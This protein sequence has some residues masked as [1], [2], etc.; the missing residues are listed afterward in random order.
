MLA[1]K[2]K[3]DPEF[4]EIYRPFEK[5]LKEYESRAKR[6]KLFQ[7]D[8]KTRLL[9]EIDN[10]LGKYTTKTSD[11]YKDLIRIRNNIKAMQYLPQNIA[12]QKAIEH[13]YRN[14]PKKDRRNFAKSLGRVSAQ[15][16]KRTSKLLLKDYI[17]KGFLEEKDIDI[18]RL[19]A[20]VIDSYYYKSSIKMI[21]DWAN[22]KGMIQPAS[23]ALMEKGWY[24]TGDMGIAS[25]ELKDKMVHPLLGS[26]LMEMGEMR[27]FGGGGIIKRTLGMS[28]VGQFIKPSI[29]WVYDIF[30][31]GYGGMYNL[32]PISEGKDFLKAWTTVANKTEDYHDL[33][34]L[35]LYQF[36]HETPV[37]SKKQAIKFLIR[38]TDKNIP[39]LV[40]KLEKITGM[41][42]DLGDM[43]LTDPKTWVS[44]YEKSDIKAVDLLMMP[45]KVLSNMTWFGDKIIRT[46]SVLSLE[47][48]GYTR[49][50]AVN[51]AARWHGAYSEVSKRYKDKMGYITFVHTFRILMPRQMMRVFYDP[52]A[53]GLKYK[54]SKQRQKE[55]RPETKSNVRYKRMA[56]SIVFTILL[57]VLVD[58]YMKSRDWETDKFGWKW[59]KKVIDPTTGI[60][61]EIVWAFN[62]IFNMPL[63]WY[64]RLTKPDPI[65]TATKFAPGFER[66]I[67]WELHPVYRLLIWDT[68]NNNKSFGTNERIWMPDDSATVKAAKW[69][70]YMFLEMFRFWGWIDEKMVPMIA[71]G[72]LT[73]QEVVRQKRIMDDA[74]TGLEQFSMYLFGYPYIRQNLDERRSIKMRQLETA[75]QQW[76]N[77]VTRNYIDIDTGDLTPEGDSQLARASEWFVK[78]IDWINNDME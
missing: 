12:V 58:T 63:K 68:R 57:P 29:I 4:M 35:N 31:K 40:R 49:T 76:S 16:K 37:L 21:L 70:K 71:S 11:G 36:P 23:D 60:E 52:I 59:K 39:N 9:E 38:Q 26:S 48:M 45:F 32:N 42:W 77:E 13:K 72:D 62:S 3:T 19:T 24:N 50:E 34:K 27:K 64:H 74:L 17:D 41:S 8:L 69:S 28:K 54:D 51:E 30:Q 5:L 14:V 65:G 18:R 6:D 56:K 66:F 53:E 55:G 47:R 67:K 7:S 73:S 25:P 46:Q 61:V 43:K 22:Q 78:T 15:F 75:F 44:G 33:N 20:E 2:E 10:E 1:E